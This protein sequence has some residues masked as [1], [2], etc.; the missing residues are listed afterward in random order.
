VSA[1][2]I[3]IFLFLS[4]G[5]AWSCSAKQNDLRTRQQLLFSDCI[6]VFFRELLRLREVLRAKRLLHFSYWPAIS[7][8][9]LHLH[10]LSF[11]IAA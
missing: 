2:Y 9:P 8:T 1:G 4:L 5:K 10:Y 11:R 7:M 3:V 6:L